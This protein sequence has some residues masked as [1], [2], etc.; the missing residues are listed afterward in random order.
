MYKRLILIS[1]LFYSALLLGQNAQLGLV[2]FNKERLSIN[3]QGMQILGAWAVASMAL[4]ASQL[5]KEPLQQAYHQMNLGWNTVNLAIAGFGLYQSLNAA[6]DLSLS[7]S[8]QE[9]ISIEK[10][11]AINAALDVAYMAGGFYLREYANR[12]DNPQRYEGFGRAVIVNGA[13]LFAF[14][15]IMYWVHKQHF[16]Q[17]LLPLLEGLS[18]SSE[19]VGIRIRF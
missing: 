8:L 18:V 14:D 10:I 12:S 2:D 16:N 19:Q 17:E 13:F 4:S 11:L 9:Q 15:V 1:F 3:K 6:T 5:R 7:E